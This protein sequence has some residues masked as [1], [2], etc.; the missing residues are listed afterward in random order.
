MVQ[1]S[2]VLVAVSLSLFL[3][4]PY[5]VAQGKNKWFKQQFKQGEGG[6]ANK[7]GKRQADPN[8]LQPLWTRIDQ[9]IDAG[10]F[11]E[12]EAAARRSIARATE[13][14]GPDRPPVMQGYWRLSRI[15]S[16]QSRF[17][18]AEQAARRAIAISQ[19]TGNS[20]SVARLSSFL[21]IILLNQGRQSEAEAL[22][23]QSLAALEQNPGP[24]HWFTAQHLHNFSVLRNEQG[25]LADAERLERRALAIYEKALGPRTVWSARS[26]AQLALIS[27]NLTR[28]AEAEDY[29]KRAFAIWETAFGARHWELA[30][31]LRL[32]GEVYARTGRYS[33]A[34]AFLRRS[35][36]VLEDTVGLEHR[37]AIF[38]M[39][40]LGE[41]KKEMGEPGEAE[42]ILKRAL[43]SIQKGNAN[44]INNLAHI[45]R[46]LGRVLHQQG[47]TEEAG[48]HMKSSL[49]AAE[50]IGKQSAYAALALVG[51]GQNHIAA[52]RFDDARLALERALFI[53]E[54]SNIVDKNDVSLILPGI[55]RHFAEL[56]LL[57]NRPAEAL[58]NLKRIASAH[59]ARRERAAALMGDSFNN[60]IRPLLRW[61]ALGFARAAWQ[62][63]QGGEQ[64]SGDAFVGAQYDNELVTSA[65]IRQMA[66]RFSAADDAI[67]QLVR[68]GQDLSQRWQALDRRLTGELQEGSS[69]A[70]A[71]RALR[72]ETDGISKE[73]T[74][75]GRRIAAEF[76]R[77]AAL[78]RS[79]PLSIAEIQKQ[80]RPDEVMLTFLVGQDE[81]FVW[82]IDQGEARWQRLELGQAALSERVARFRNGLDIAKLQQG[83]G[84]GAVELF[85]L[86]LA[87]QLYRELLGPVEQ[88]LRGK[89][90]LLV[91]PSGPLTSLPFHL[92]VGSPPTRP[93]TE[94]T[95]ILEYRDADWMV[96]RYAI[97]ILPSVASVNALRGLAKPAAGGKPLIGFGAPVFGA[98]NSASVVGAM[99]AA[100]TT[101][102]MTR[103][104]SA[105]WKGG[106]VDL[107]ALAQGLSPLPE[108]ADELRG[109]AKALGAPLEDIHLG[110]AASEVTVKRSDLGSYRV[111]YFA[112]HGLVAGEV[113]GLGEPALALTTPE[114]ATALDDG[115][116]TASEVAQLKLNA[117]WVVLSAC[118][119]AAG[120]KT[121]AEAFS[122][123]ARA[124][125]YAG[126]RALLVSHWPVES[127]AAVKLTT[128]AFE[129]LQQSPGLGRAEALRQSMF[130]FMNDASDPLN[131]YP[132]FWAP[133]ALVGEAGD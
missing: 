57:T 119:T 123:L 112:T 68:K 27:S 129:A 24:E 93:I 69:D 66:I 101:K 9:L 126:A 42:L 77:Y 132:A 34:E 75:I 39:R 82:A 114:T 100:S 49:E 107:A 44:D 130:A 56:N 23:T 38:T 43:G 3:A 98:A 33:D 67:G 28:Y 127:G 12:A 72:A 18:E 47:R 32:L 102:R 60:E 11:T 79:A 26:L 133:F 40:S 45:H 5:A 83:A 46:L 62:L 70:N 106:S 55:L 104:Y 124:F 85:D 89:R 54:N 90:K 13:L 1:L 20:V 131:A 61:V 21:G 7:E 16:I 97:A 105:Y 95:Q 25:R 10:K 86:E 63:G 113:T 35:L 122:G 4:S 110:P 17:R 109:A 84:T 73:L 125:F 128:K 36:Q 71:R 64:Y 59:E 111:V 120:D 108:T 116:L 8:E 78:T 88:A 117:D 81:S 65:A 74:E 115:L 14:F 80:I 91:V 58:D 94:L 53:A 31:G 30:H 22:F 37:N 118:N 19:K 92:L 48:G 2:V 15:L 96:K 50:R 41:L 121:G 51:L 103:T 52:K 87:F 6:P 29:L 99:P 76:P